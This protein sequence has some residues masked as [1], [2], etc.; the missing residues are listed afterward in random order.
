MQCEK[1]GEN[2]NLHYFLVMQYMLDGH[3]HTQAGALN[4]IALLWS[5]S[6]IELCCILLC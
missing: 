6:G 2:K 1:E 5:E 3:R 4:K